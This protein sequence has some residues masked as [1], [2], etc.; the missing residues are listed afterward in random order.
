MRER[1]RSAER[2]DQLRGL[3]QRGLI[4]RGR[5]RCHVAQQVA[6][7]GIF[8]FFD[9]PGR[10]TRAREIVER[11]LARFRHRADARQPTAR[12]GECAVQHRARCCLCESYIHDCLT[13][14]AA[15]SYCA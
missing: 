8:P 5:Q 10:Q 1:S 4:R 11:L 2:F 15:S 14:A 7:V 6:Q 9:P 13:Q 3:C 12:G